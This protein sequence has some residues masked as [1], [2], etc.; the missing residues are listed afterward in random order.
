MRGI[1]ARFPLLRRAGATTAFAAFLLLCAPPP[2]LSQ[3][4]PGQAYHDLLSQGHDRVARDLTRLLDLRS[5]PDRD[6]VE[7]FL[8]RWD[9]D[10]DGPESGYRTDVAASRRGESG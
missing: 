7:D 9:D 6:D 5:R 10:A 3:S 1:V 2:S 4:M 8:E